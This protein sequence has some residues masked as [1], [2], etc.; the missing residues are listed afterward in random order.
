MVQFG[1]YAPNHATA[2]TFAFRKELLDQTSFDENACVA[3]ERTFLKEYTIPFLQLDTMKTILV[4]SH[5]HNSFDKKLMLKDGENNFMKIVPKTPSDFVKEADILNFFMKDI[6][7]LLENYKPGDPIFKPDVLK[8]IEEIK[9]KREEKIKEYQK[10]INSPAFIDLQNKL[11]QMS[12]FNQ[13]LT[14]ENNLL[15]DKNK[16]FE[17]KITQLIQDLIELKKQQKQIK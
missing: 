11:N 12:I 4:F 15:K 17:T 14:M 1:P 9:I 6:D 13:E 8:Q 10:V 16:Y 3:E 2:A 7:I 5:I